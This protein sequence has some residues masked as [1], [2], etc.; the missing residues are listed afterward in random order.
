V[1]ENA[2][3]VISDQAAGYRTET[4]EWIVIFLI[5]LEVVLATIH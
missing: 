4:L 5:A 1:A 3:Q 2:Y